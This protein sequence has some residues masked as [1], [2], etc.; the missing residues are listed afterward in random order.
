MQRRAGVLAA[1]R[2]GD[3]LVDKMG[4][5]MIDHWVGCRDEDAGLNRSSGERRITMGGRT[6]G[7]RRSHSGQIR[8]RKIIIA[9]TALVVVISLA[10]FAANGGV[11]GLF[12][13]Q[14]SDIPPVD[15]H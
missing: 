8:R 15:A 11:T 7:R 4:D 6:R 5:Q 2:D 13:V 9:S 12:E 10:I 14:G 3:R 1:A